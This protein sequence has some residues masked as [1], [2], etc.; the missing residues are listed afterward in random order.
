M[1]ASSAATSRSRINMNLREDKHWSYGARTLL[2]GAR[3]QRPFMAYA[4]VQTD[5][6]KESLVE[7][8]KELTGIINRP[9]H[10]GCGTG[11]NPAATHAGTR[12]AMGDHERGERFDS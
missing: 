8:E 5:K 11:Q 1:N 6:T 2:S 4:P 12:R 7:M 3:G 10:H 9:S